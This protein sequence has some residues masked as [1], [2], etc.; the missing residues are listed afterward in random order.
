MDNNT[1]KKSKMNLDDLIQL[2]EPKPITAFPI[3]E[4]ELCDRYE[5]LYTSAVNDVLR[6]FCLVDQALPPEIHPLRDDMKVCGIAYT[7]RSSK[8]PIITGEMDTRAK[9]LDDMPRNCICV[10]DASGEN[11]AAHWGEIMTASAIARGAKGAVVDG[12]LRD[13]VQVLQQHFPVFNKYRT[14]NG[15]LARCRITAYNVPVKIGK[16]LIYPGDVV[17][18]DIDGVVIVP[19]QFAYPALLRAEEIKTG[20]VSIRQ[21]VENGM[22]AKEVVDRGGYF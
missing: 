17:F 13:T 4:E 16:V 11:E 9:M 7:I 5:K 21:W 22:S 15:T 3:A 18:G 1:M 20:E 10:W 8:D 12:G 19:R 2:R 14:S 6:E